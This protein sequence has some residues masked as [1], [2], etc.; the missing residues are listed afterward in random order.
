MFA[1]DNGAHAKIVSV[2]EAA[3]LVY[4]SLDV[5]PLGVACGPLMVEE[6]SDSVTRQVS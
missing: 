1:R 4:G 3:R 6:A 5:P 2:F